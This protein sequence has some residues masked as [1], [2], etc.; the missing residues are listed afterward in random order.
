MNAK[1][2]GLALLG[3]LCS[4]VVL[5]QA[6]TQALAPVVVTAT[7]SERIALDVPAS[8]DVIDREAVRDTQWRIN[9]SE[10]L[11]TVPGVVVLNRQNHAQ[12]L[13]ISMRGF[14]ARATFG[15]RGVRLYVDGV[16]A[17]FPDGQGQ[18]SHFPLN[19]A[20]R[21]EVLRG[22]FSALYGNAS[23]GVI[24]L[25]TDL[26]PQPQ[27]YEPSAA[28]GAFSTWRLGL[29]GHGGDAPY[30]FLVDAGRFRTEG[31]RDHS[32]ARRN[33]ATI[34]TAFLD[35]PLG[36]LRISLNALDM[37]DAQDPLG[38]TRAQW[39]A[40]PRQASPQ[41]L[42]FNTRKSTR[43]GTFGAE[44]KSP[45]GTDS[46]LTATAWLGHREVTQF[47]AIPTAAQASPTHPGG[48]IDFDRDFAGIDLRARFDLGL[49]TAHVGLAVETMQ[50]DRRGYENFIG[51]TLG[52]QGSLRRDETNRVVATDP[53]AQI[54]WHFAEA[55][56]LH[57]GV[58]AS[59]VRFRSRDHYIVG[60]NGDD[61]GVVSFA[62]VNP[63]LG[64]VYR[65]TPE[66][67]VYAAYGRGFETPTLNELAYRPDGSAGVNTA[68]RAA[69]SD[70][71]E[72]GLKYAWTP[73]L[74]SSLALFSIRTRDDLVVATNVGGRS[75]F[76][77]VGRTRRD[78]VELALQG[79]LSERFAITLSAAAIDARYDTDFLTCGPPPCTTPTVA[80]ARGKK[81]PGVPAHTAALQTRYRSSWADF[82][83][84]LKAQSKLFVNDLNSEYA[85][86][87]AVA[88]LAV[89][90]TVTVGQSQA[91]LYVRVDN[92]FDRRYVGSVI[93]N[94]ANSRF[95]EPA[96][97]RTWAAGIDWTL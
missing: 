13:Q 53:Y 71:V 70:H 63:S 36:A 3:A 2:Y 46:Q 1:R 34:R 94:E 69:K 42:Q 85:P 79:R 81:L 75:A 84:E 27:R 83:W 9:L 82:T 89:A 50:E 76:A 74:R 43:Q 5:A 92:L 60:V 64:I 47:Q 6:D 23:G 20:E 12:D 96:P 22:P 56:H 44:L 39:Q 73:E 58:R 26:K 80:V 7:R 16:P 86:G 67:A 51:S 11:A 41:A 15:V 31:Y 65:P 33:S 77:N 48:V 19:A 72:I 49:L 61:S 38:L 62:A 52:I 18:V 93:V 8:V 24:A 10:S 29:A 87:Y 17:S 25:T 4:G 14:G 68:L 21:I 35:S 57:A 45:I 59:E 66:A 88:N 91:R 54:E 95:F 97:G 90:R 32:A 30:A 40:N 37:P 78:G 55:W 28:I